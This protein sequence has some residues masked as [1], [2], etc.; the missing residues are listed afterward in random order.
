MLG[1]RTVIYHVSDLARAKAWYTEAFGVAPYF[2]QPFYVGYNIGGYELGLHP[3][4]P[5]RQPGP[6]GTAAYW[7][8]DDAHAEHARLLGLG[9]TSYE[10]VKDVGEGILV[11]AVQDADGNIVGIIQNPH[12][13]LPG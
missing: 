6:G 12:F 13:T 11:G 9:A 10:A 1:L 4:T 3:I 2:D 5:Q 8:V 7:G